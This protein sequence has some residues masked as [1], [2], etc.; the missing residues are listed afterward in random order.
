MQAVK[1]LYKEGGI[2]LL[3]PIVGVDEAELF[4]IVLDKNTDANGIAQS[5]RTTNSNAEQDF[6]AIGMNSFFDTENDNNIDWE[7]VFDVKPR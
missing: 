7:D 4:V 1:A 6:Q 2:H 5:F 3:T